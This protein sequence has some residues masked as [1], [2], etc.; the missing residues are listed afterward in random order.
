[1]GS[2]LTLRLV[3]ESQEGKIGD[4]WKYTLSAKVYNEGLKGEG[5]ISVK[6]HT[7]ATGTTQEP[8]GPPEALVMNAG[9]SG[10]SLNI[11]LHLH[12]TEVDLFKSDSGEHSLQVSMNTPQPGGE[13]I[14][15]N[16]D[17]SVG[18]QESPGFVDQTAI[19]TLKLELVSSSD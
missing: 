4:D 9:E 18:V 15:L 14:T 1:M 5:S 12:A 16:T 3:S 2:K 6:K 7:L 13:P 19:L 17:I 11:K 10:K 8:P